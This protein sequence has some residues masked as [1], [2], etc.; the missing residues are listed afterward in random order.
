MIDADITWQ[1][2]CTALAGGDYE[3]AFGVLSAALDEAAPAAVGKGKGA[4]VSPV[5]ALICVYLGS[6]HALYGDAAAEQLEAT[7]AEARGLNPVVS[8]EPLYLALNAELEARTRGP[9]AAPPAGA[10]REAVD[11]VARF[12]ALCALALAEQP[13]A[14]LDIHLGAGELP[15]HLRWR[16]RSWQ[17]DCQEQLGH[18]ADAINLYAEAAHLASGL[19]RA[20]MLQE[21]AALLIQDGQPEEA[22]KVLDGARLLYGSKQAPQVNPANPGQGE[23]EG[24]NLA[25]WHYLRAQALLQM[26]QADAA[27]EMVR[28]ADRLERQYGTPGYVVALLSGQILSHLGQQEK[29][30]TAFEAALKLAE[31]SDL[32]YANHEL[33]VALLDM[34]RP[35]E[36]R[37]RLEVA[38]NEPDYPYQPEVLA[39]IAECDYRLGRM[40]EAQLAAEQALAQGAVIP[41]SLVL[42]SVALDYFQLDEA[43]EHY[44]RV[45]REAAPDSR[46]WIIGHQMAADVMAQQGFP[47]PAAAI[48][49]AQQ[50]L[51]LTPESDDW[52]GTLQDL[53]ARAQTL[54]GQQDG[55][56]L[57]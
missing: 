40:P 4:A 3:T 48:A 32:P 17:A 38:L 12:H 55:R 39:D 43:L 29:A 42:G 25:T 13:Q 14:A 8:S 35:V 31:D 15:V 33:G 7:L 28:E 2:A 57:N 23:D 1:Q 19:D 10:M 50:A 18:T 5:A 46:D 51:I 56:M 22:R 6:L 26:D 45:V 9:E 53:L 20:V 36:A 52:H 54:M 41:A 11:P 34:D 49:H 44:E 37:D 24:L 27:Y 30:I 16:L 47:D 21:Q